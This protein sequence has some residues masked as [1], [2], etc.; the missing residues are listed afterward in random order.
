M[1]R[2]AKEVDN[3]DNHTCRKNKN[4]ANRPTT[5][6]ATTTKT[7]TANNKQQQEQHWGNQAFVRFWEEQYTF[8]GD[9]VQLTINDIQREL[10]IIYNITLRP[11]SS[12]FFFCI[13]CEISKLHLVR[14]E[15]FWQP[16]PLGQR[17]RCRK[18]SCPCGPRFT[19]LEAEHRETKN[20]I[21]RLRSGWFGVPTFF[22]W[23][24]Q[25]TMSSLFMISMLHNQ[26]GLTISDDPFLSPTEHKWIMMNQYWPCESHV[27]GGFW[28]FWFWIFKMCGSY[29][30]FH[31][32]N[33]YQFRHFLRLSSCTELFSI[34]IINLLRIIY[35]KKKKNIKNPSPIRKH[36]ILDLWNPISHPDKQKRWVLSDPVFSASTPLEATTKVKCVGM[37]TVPQPWTIRNPSVFN[38]FL[39]NKH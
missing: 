22:V 7:K 38:M 8:E 36:K 18:S 4:E 19:S 16:K 33:V 24:F 1:P 15:R 17:H 6:T 2:Y 26:F 14:P 5:A 37:C 34:E 31:K 9:Y 3:N 32:I 25:E 29:Q 11:I 12:Y 30:F 20:N 23:D 13:T 21:M 39:T 35:K 10:H 27:P 28:S